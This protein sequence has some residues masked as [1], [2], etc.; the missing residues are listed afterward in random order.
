MPAFFAFTLAFGAALLFVI[1]PIAA[2]SALPVLGGSP[3]VWNTSMVFFQAVV[4]AGYG[5]AHLLA[6]RLP[7]KAQ[8]LAFVLAVIGGA[9]FLPGSALPPSD[10]PTTDPV[11]WLLGRLTTQWAL[12]CF[13]LALASPL[14]QRWYTRVTRDQRE[15][16]VLYSASNAGSLGALLAYPVILEP[17]LDLDRQVGLWSTAFL[18]W[19]L[20]IAVAA[21]L[22][23]RPASS[24]PLEPADATP[25]PRTPPPRPARI[26][27]WTILGAIPASLL[28]G[29]TLF[30][31]TDVA[32]VPLLWVVPLALYL[33]TFIVAFA[34]RAKPLVAAAN[35]A[36]PFLASALLYVVLSRAT[37]PVA[38]LVLLHLAFLFLAGVACHGRLVAARPAPEHLT[39]FYFALA[40]GGVLGGAFNALLAPQLFRSVTEYPLAIALACATLPPR[41]PAPAP[42]TS[43]H[44]VAWAR[45]LAW[46]TVIAVGMAILGLA[47]PWWA[48]GSSRLRDALVF[49]LP[50]VACCTLL[51]RPRRL[52]LALGAVF[53]VG[54]RLQGLWSHTDHAERNF[55]G[56]TR[57]TVDPTSGSHQIVHGNT[58][59]GRQFQDAARRNE[60]LT[61]YHR[62]GPLGAAFDAFRLL[63]ARNPDPD[64]APARIGVIGLGAG[65]MA[66]YAAA[67][68]LWTFFEIDPAVIRVARDPRWFSFLRDTRAARLDIVEG[69]ARL[70]LGQQ[71]DRTFDL[72]VLDAFSS[73]AIPV[74]LLT[75]EALALYLRKLRPG[76]WLL[77]HVSNRYLDLEPVLARL[78]ADAG[79]VCRAFDDTHED[80]SVGKEASHWILMARRES[81]LGP[82]S[83]RKEWVPALDGRNRS[84]WTDRKA[85][86][87]EAFE[88]R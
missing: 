26:L 66:S 34:P 62:L 43:G 21:F 3:A 17:T 2:R 29:G 1:Q 74:H 27:A 88:W 63:R 80:P 51:D 16:Y 81:D 23:Q 7:P 87:F 54:L 75:R 32:S 44:A 52:A 10:A 14:L 38:V 85:G 70:R 19:G 55:F 31:T 77:T 33:V 28:Q 84:P 60:P 36:L 46:T 72:L 71:P 4:L 50:A 58:I 15:P 49:G 24:S 64:T 56:V 25:R 86:V 76:G 40:G 35:R 22:Q 11:P 6:R 53:L 57:V 68:D 79:I 13:A 8:G 83:R 41:G 78:A 73:D 9:A 45:D 18:A 48:E 20:G 59:H 39:T 42:P 47:V 30:L 37:Q 67:S 12:P 61:Y 5:A 65:S 82:V 69:D